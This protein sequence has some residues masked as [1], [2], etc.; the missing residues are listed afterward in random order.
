MGSNARMDPK[1]PQNFGTW[2]GLPLQL[3]PRNQFF[4]SDKPEPP[5]PLTGIVTKSQTVVQG[6]K[7]N[8]RLILRFN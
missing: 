1:L 3:L 4:H 5:P 6:V 8:I 2:P 7:M